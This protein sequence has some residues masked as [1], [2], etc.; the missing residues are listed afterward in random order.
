MYGGRV[1]G[2]A[3]EASEHSAGVTLIALNV[4]PGGQPPA[5]NRFTDLRLGGLP[6]G[7]PAWWLPYRHI[8]LLG[9]QDTSPLGLRQLTLAR[10]TCF[11]ATSGDSVWIDGLVAGSIEDVACF[12]AGAPSRFTV[13]R[14]EGVSGR[15]LNLQGSYQFGLNVNSSFVSVGGGLLL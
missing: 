8:Q 4:A 12:P 6:T 11:G 14:S 15:G 1:E 13:V 2:L 10:I 9:R 5:N 3:I 7:A